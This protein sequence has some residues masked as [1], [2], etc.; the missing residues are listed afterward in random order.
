MNESREV[1]KP[2][3]ELTP[4][5]KARY[6]IGAKKKSSD[7]KPVWIKL[8]HPELLPWTG[9][10][11]LVPQKGILVDVIY[12]R[13]RRRNTPQSIFLDFTRVVPIVDTPYASLPISAV[14]ID[15]GKRE[16]W[17]DCAKAVDAGV[18]ISFN[19]FIERSQN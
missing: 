17:V 11:G 5:E 12:D 9:M 7:E 19:R 3:P 6:L 15:P 16:V 2:Q 8:K 18:G 13:S 10:G 4:R 14:E 1:S